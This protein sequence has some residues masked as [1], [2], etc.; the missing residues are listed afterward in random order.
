M[1]EQKLVFD[2]YGA[3]Q[4]GWRV[5]DEKCSERLYTREEMLHLT[6]F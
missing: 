5:N 6:R 1:M 2:A 3:F 4:K